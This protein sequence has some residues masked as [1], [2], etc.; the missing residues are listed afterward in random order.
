MKP[1]KHCKKMKSGGFRWPLVALSTLQG[2]LRLLCATLMTASNTIA[3]HLPPHFVG[4]VLSEELI[5]CLLF[6]IF[7]VQLL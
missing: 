4:V 1:L 7:S 3:E 2:S 6:R 5:S